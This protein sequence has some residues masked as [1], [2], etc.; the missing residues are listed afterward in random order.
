ML[1]PIARCSKFGW[2]SRT[3]PNCDALCDIISSGEVANL[4]T[5]KY[6]CQARRDK[7]QK[8]SIM[9]AALCKVVRERGF[10]V[11]LI[12]RYSH[13]CSRAFDNSHILSVRN[14]NLCVHAGSCLHWCDVML[15]SDA[16]SSGAF[17]SR[18]IGDVVAIYHFWWLLLQCG[19]Q[20]GSEQSEA[21]SHA[22]ASKV[23]AACKQRSSRSNTGADT[24]DTVLFSDKFLQN[25]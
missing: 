6:V 8:D 14:W 20:Q 13:C 4:Y 3:S 7:L 24:V 10:K 11:A 16:N 21:K 23:P 2:L 15:E 12:A 1:L 18:I 5:F 9:Y 17:T 25:A 19:Y 22:G